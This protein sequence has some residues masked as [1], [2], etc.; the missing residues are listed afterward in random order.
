MRRQSSFRRTNRKHFGPPT[1][2]CRTHKLARFRRPL[3]QRCAAT[4]E[5]FRV[6]TDFRKPAPGC[7]LS[8]RR[9]DKQK[10]NHKSSCALRP[11]GLRRAER[12]LRGF[13]RTIRR[14]CGSKIHREWQRCTQKRSVTA[15]SERP[16]RLRGAVGTDVY[17]G[18]HR[19]GNWPASRAR[20][21]RRPHRSLSPSGA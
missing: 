8:A 17:S 12:F 5:L 10:I 6:R 19:M 18:G 20:R 21:P 2:A 16:S 13:G 7:D 4:G 14:N 1:N 3:W 9:P 15:P 11:C